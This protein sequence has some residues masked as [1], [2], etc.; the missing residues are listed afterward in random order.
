MDGSRG[1]TGT[2]GSSGRGG[3]SSRARRALL[4]AAALAAA[5]GCAPDKPRPELVARGAQYQRLAV[6]CAPAPG[7]DPGYVSVIMQQ[8]ERMAPSRLDFLQRVDVLTGA[9]LDPS[10]T[11]PAVSLPSDAPYDGI[12]ALVYSHAGPVVLD[13]YMLDVATR[14]Q[15]WHHRLSTNDSDVADRLT[16]HGYWTP[17][18]I[19]QHFYGR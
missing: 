19:K 14:A 6:V 5:V 9:E 17:T 11:P 18:T 16:R 12:V 13:I 4:A 2:V 7:A 8:V 1:R 3:A 10:A 15:V